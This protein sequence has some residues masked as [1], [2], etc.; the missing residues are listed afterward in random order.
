MQGWRLRS[1]V[2]L[3]FRFEAGFFEQQVLP[4]F[5]DIPMSHAPLARVLHLADALRETGPI[6]VYYDRRGLEPGP[7]PRTDFQRIGVSHRTGY[8]HP[9]NVLLLVESTAPQAEWGGPRRPARLI[10]A[11]MSANLT[12]AGWWENVEVAHIETAVP[13]T[14]CGFRNDVLSLLAL[15]RRI[16]PKGQSHPALD[17]IDSLLRTCEQDPQRL[18]DGVLLPRLFSGNVDLCEFLNDVAGNRLRNRCVEVISPYFDDA[19]SLKP[20]RALIDR[21]RPQETRI[22][23]PRGMTGEALCS[24][25]YWEAIQAA[26]A[27]WGTLPRDVV[28]LSRDTDR[29]VHAKVFRFFDPGDRRQTLFIGSVNL[30]N[31]GFGKSGNIETGFLVE[32]EGRRRSDWWLEADES[33]PTDFTAKSESEGLAVGPGANLVLR[34]DWS[35]ETAKAFWD[36]TKRSP[37]LV[38]RG[39]G[40]KLGDIEPLDSQ[41]W[42]A[43]DAGI[44][45][46]LREHLLSSSFVTVAVDGEPEATILVD[47]EGAVDKPSLLS[48][49]SPEDILQFWSLLTDAQKQE[50]FET[51]IG[52]LGDH[53]L[54]LWMRDTKA[55]ATQP[56]LFGTFAHVFLSLGNLERAV[57]RA[58]ADGRRKEATDRLFGRKFDSV[59][60][61]VERVSEKE[62]PDPV[63]DYITI[64]CA[65]QLLEVLKKDEPEF[66][67]IERDRF[68]LVVKARN[69]L[70]PLKRR[71]TFAKESEQQTFFEWFEQWFLR[72]AAAVAKEPAA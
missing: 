32:I 62:Q 57:R 44:A 33:R 72:R 16:S 43:I 30:T 34:F 45:A 42:T 35:T 49:L 67:A 54:T 41:Q 38:I 19:E 63:R 60:R 53:E 69:L 17:E 51:H 46:R 68:E 52:E 20:I 22:F 50:F 12:Q 64:L 5:F 59:R 48:T 14:L 15:L 9:K 8:F 40:V 39:S 4:I 6:A 36:A 56:G 65:I 31:A 28:K 71:F 61:L 21:F 10:V 47:E 25:Q 7:A 18:R 24:Q 11:S 70:S 55:P 13:G 29:F 23:L 27:I 2:F 1:G 26:G 58:L 3:T 37:R 66:Y